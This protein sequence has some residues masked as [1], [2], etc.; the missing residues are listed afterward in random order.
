MSGTSPLGA[1]K[2]PTN[3]VPPNFWSTDLGVCGDMGGSIWEYGRVYFGRLVMVFGGA[4][5][6]VFGILGVS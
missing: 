1:T 2:V 6:W 3:R 5:E 4:P